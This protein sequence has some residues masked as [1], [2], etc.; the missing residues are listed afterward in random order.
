MA[1][2]T[3]LVN[4]I[5]KLILGVCID[6]PF[7]LEDGDEVVCVYRYVIYIPPSARLTGTGCSWCSLLGSVGHG[8]APGYRRL[9]T[10][11]VDFCSDGC[12][13]CSLRLI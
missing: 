10:F 9:L 11:P 3:F 2:I 1:L 5:E 12:M 8:S 7:C 6:V 13:I 4:V